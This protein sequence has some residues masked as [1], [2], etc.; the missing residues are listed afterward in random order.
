MLF[1]SKFVAYVTAQPGVPRL[2]DVSRALAE[3]SARAIVDLRAA[4]QQLQ[5]GGMLV[6]RLLPPPA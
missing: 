2:G 1:R 3:S 6:F 4:T 5:D